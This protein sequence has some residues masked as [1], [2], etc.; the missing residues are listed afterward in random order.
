MIAPSSPYHNSLTDNN[1]NVSRHKKMTRVHKH[2]IPP[3]EYYRS[4]FP[5][6]RAHTILHVHTQ[7]ALSIVG[8][9]S[10]VVTADLQTPAQLTPAVGAVATRKHHTAGEE[11]ARS[12]TQGE[13]T[14]KQCTTSEYSNRLCLCIIAT[15]CEQGDWWQLHMCTLHTPHAQLSDSSLLP[16]C[17]FVNGCFTQ[18]AHAHTDCVWY[19]PQL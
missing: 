12:S 9:W 6:T 4:V 16:G 15:Q 7:R 10:S 19:T 3:S 8:N 13:A 17:M 1:K 11:Q 5:F 2:S 18:N 14:Y